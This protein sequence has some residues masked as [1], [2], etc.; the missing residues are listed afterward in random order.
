V[1]RSERRVRRHRLTHSCGRRGPFLF[2]RPNRRNRAW[3][4]RIAKTRRGKGLRRARIRVA[5]R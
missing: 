4:I 2:G 3:T 5:Y 1:L